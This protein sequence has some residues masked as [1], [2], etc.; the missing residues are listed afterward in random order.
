M[1]DDLWESIE[2]AILSPLCGTIPRTHTP[3]GPTAAKSG[4]RN[5]TPAAGNTQPLYSGYVLSFAANSFVNHV[6]NDAFLNSPPWSRFVA[7][8]KS[9]SLIRPVPSGVR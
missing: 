8:Q 5:K 9:F 1:N 6:G 3:A 4:A 2:M 7:T